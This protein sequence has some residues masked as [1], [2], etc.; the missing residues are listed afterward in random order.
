MYTLVKIITTHIDSTYL[1][2]CRAYKQHAHIGE[3]GEKLQ[4]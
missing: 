4:T 3:T 1:V 2:Y